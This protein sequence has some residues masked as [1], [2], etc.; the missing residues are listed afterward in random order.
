[1]GDVVRLR[2]GLVGA[3]LVAEVRAAQH[4]V[5][6]RLEHALG[7]PLERV[8]GHDLDRDLVLARHRMREHVDLDGELAELLEVRGRLLLVLRAHERL[9]ERV[10]GLRV[11]RE[12]VVQA[13]ELGALL[14]ECLLEAVAV[15]VEE[16]LDLIECAL[17]HL[18]N[19][20]KRN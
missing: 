13:G 19:N 16:R 9:D 8:G 3:L 10:G 14:D 7:A 15:G 20:K 4:A 5:D 17:H 18:G 2:L 12:R 6:E 1:M 11:E